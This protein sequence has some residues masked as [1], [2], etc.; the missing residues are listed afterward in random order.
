MKIGYARVSTQEQNIDLQLNALRKYECSVIYQEK[1]SG[2]NSDRPE[3]KKVLQ[4][5][6]EEDVL[7][8]WKLDRLGR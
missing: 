5:V 1:K 6:R 3:L 4:S 7:V 8:I 2:K